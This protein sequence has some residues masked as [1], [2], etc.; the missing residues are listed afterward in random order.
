MYGWQNVKYKFIRVKGVNQP[1]DIEELCTSE[2]E[3]S[4]EMI[5]LFMLTEI[6]KT[7]LRNDERLLIRI[8]YDKAIYYNESDENDEEEPELMHFEQTV[9]SKL[10]GFAEWD[11]IYDDNGWGA[12]RRAI[13]DYFKAKI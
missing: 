8:E 4:Q 1:F 13:V 2:N 10:P 6:D 5:E 3:I 9:A 11:L 7:N 12:F